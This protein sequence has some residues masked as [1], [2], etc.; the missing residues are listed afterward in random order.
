[1]FVIGVFIGFLFVSN[2]VFQ[3][4]A[5]AAKY[6]S[7][8]YMVLQSIILIDLFYMLSIGWVR[9]YDAG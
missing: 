4:Y 2:S 3:D 6:I 5:T 1:M 9:K 7:I 8:V